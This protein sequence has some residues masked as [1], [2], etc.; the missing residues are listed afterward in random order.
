VLWIERTWSNGVP[1]FY[2]GTDTVPSASPRALVRLTPGSLQASLPLT[3]KRYFFRARDLSQEL[4][5]AFRVLAERDGD[6]VMTFRQRGS[7][8]LPNPDTLLTIV[9]QSN[10]VTE[11]F[12]PRRDI[13]GSPVAIPEGELASLLSMESWEGIIDTAVAD[14]NGQV[15]LEWL[16]PEQYFTS[17]YQPTGLAS[18]RFTYIPA[19]ADQPLYDLELAAFPLRMRDQAFALAEARTMWAGAGINHYQVRHSI[20]CFCAVEEF[21]T[22]FRV[23]NG[24]VLDPEYLMPN[25]FLNDHPDPEF[26]PTVETAFENMVYTMRRAHQ[27]WLRFDPATGAPMEHAVDWDGDF[28][29]DET[30]LFYRLEALP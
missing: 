21:A 6:Y 7:A 15:S 24:Q 28:I 19:G 12:L 1:T 2:A 17:Y 13:D 10:R 5:D 4:D 30:S 23:Q 20:E 27:V 18:F 16:E 11:A 3:G 26:T 8:S 14:E 29:D 25:P 22:R 9:V